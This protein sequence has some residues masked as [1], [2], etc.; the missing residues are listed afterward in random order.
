MAVYQVSTDDLLV[1]VTPEADFWWRV[2]E[3]ALHGVTIVAADPVAGTIVTAEP[4]LGPVGGAEPEELP[5]W[6]TLVA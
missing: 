4:V 2:R 5:F 6:L 1:H 3:T